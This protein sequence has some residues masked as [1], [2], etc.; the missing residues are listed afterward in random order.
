MATDYNPHCNVCAPLTAQT[1]HVILPLLSV[2]SVYLIDFS[3]SLQIKSR[4][5]KV[6]KENLLRLQKQ[7]FI[8]CCPTNSVKAHVMKKWIHFG[9]QTCLSIDRDQL[10]SS[11]DEDFDDE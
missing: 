6:S 2:V 4:P 11:F 10:Q 5:P 9:S 1:S 8:G 7:D 3:G